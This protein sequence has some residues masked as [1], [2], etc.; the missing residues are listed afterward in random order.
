MDVDGHNFPNLA[1]L[2]LSAWHKM[3]G[4]H[5]EWWNGLKRY[6]VVYKSKVFDITYSHD[7]EYC[8][9]ADRIVEGG[10]GY[11]LDNKLPEEIEHTCP[12]YDLYGI[13]ETAYGFL[14]RGCPRDCGFCIVSQKE[15]QKSRKVADLSEF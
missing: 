5:V 4:N 12:D 10:T 9:N 2:K 6:D 3:N 1:L 7:M 11:G 13:K 8:V 15:G 14:T